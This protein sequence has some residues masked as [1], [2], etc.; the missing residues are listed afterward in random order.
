M[1]GLTTAERRF[2][3]PSFSFLIFLRNTGAIH[4]PWPYLGKAVGK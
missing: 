3:I 2:G 1:K 4:N